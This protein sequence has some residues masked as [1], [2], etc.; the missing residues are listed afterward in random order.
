MRISPRYSPQLF[1]LLMSIIM[2]FIMTGFVTWVN[3]GIDIGFADRWMH[4][5]IM[6]WPVALICILILAQ[7]IRSLV[8]KLTSQ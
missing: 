5:F 7:R 3:T 4:A 6:A 8:E 2:A 1:A